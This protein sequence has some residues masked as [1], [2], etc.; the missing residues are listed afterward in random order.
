MSEYDID[1]TLKSLL[2]EKKKD[3][4]KNKLTGLLDESNDKIVSIFDEL[5][6]KENKDGR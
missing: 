3:E 6:N 1:E 5:I 2:D 4:K